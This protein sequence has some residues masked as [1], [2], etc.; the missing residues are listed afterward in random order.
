[1]V[2]F[3]GDIH[4]PLHCGDRGDRAETGDLGR[5]RQ[6]LKDEEALHAA[7][8]MPL[9]NVLAYRYYVAEAALQAS[10]WVQLKGS[11]RQAVPP[12]KPG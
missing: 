6:R 4:Q 3:I 5:M 7:G 1:M 2:H 8:K 11:S 12:R 9:A 10:L